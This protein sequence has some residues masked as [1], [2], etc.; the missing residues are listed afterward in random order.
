MMSRTVKVKINV[1]EQFLSFMKNC[2]EIYNLHINW[3]F[4]NNSHNK[5]KAHTDLYFKIRELYP[6]IPSALIQTMRDNALESVKSVKTNFFRAKK[7]GINP[8]P[9]SKPLKKPYSSIRYDKRTIT[10]KKNILSFS[11]SGNRIKQN[12]TVPSWFLKKYPEYNFQSATI[13]YD[14]GSRQFYA[15]LTYLSHD[16]NKLENITEDKI[17]G[18]DRG[19]YNIITTSNGIK[20]NSKSIRKN[21]RKILYNKRNI[22]AKVTRSSKKKL[23]SLKKKESRFSLNQNHIISKLLVN[24]PFDIFVLEDLTNIVKSSKSKGKKLNKWLH[25]WSFFQLEQLLTY[26]ALSVG[27]S[28]VK[29]DARYTSQKCSQCGNVDKKSR[30]KDKYCCIKCGFKEHSDINAALNIKQNYL[31]S[32]LALSQKESGQEQAVVNQPNEE[33]EIINDFEF[34]NVST[35]SSDYNEGLF[36]M[37]DTSSRLSGESY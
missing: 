17:L 9:I 12:I 22:Q 23:I 36:Q 35:E 31:I 2:S 19:L 11:W 4:D 6:D 21:K 29:V 24:L 18:I 30:N 5:N 14:K 33:G 3:C 27:K 10:L 25:S 26:K 7:Q 28:I 20:I 8:K 37:L 32:L 1:P 13:S 16:I 34:F 15:N